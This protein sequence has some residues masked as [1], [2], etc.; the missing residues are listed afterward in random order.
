MIKCKNFEELFL[1]KITSRIIMQPTTKV[2]KIGILCGI[3]EGRWD[4]RS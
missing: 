3:V 2:V 4:R 1:K